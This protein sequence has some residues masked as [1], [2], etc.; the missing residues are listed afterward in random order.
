MAKEISISK[1]LE[2]R[3][4][5]KLSLE[6]NFNI[7]ANFLAKEF[8]IKLCLCNI[9][10]NRRWSYAAGYSGFIVGRKKIKINNQLGVIYSNHFEMPAKTDINSAQWFQIIS[11][12]KKITETT[13]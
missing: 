13:K 8:E 4:D 5:L 12:I 10:G 2:T 1:I 9:K 7:I 11:L 6:E 3:L